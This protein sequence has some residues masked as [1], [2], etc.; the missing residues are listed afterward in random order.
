MFLPL[1]RISIG[2]RQRKTFDAIPLAELRE[3]ILA[4]GLI[5]PL[6]VIET[7]S[8]FDLVCGERRLRAITQIYESGL[9]FTYGNS[10]VPSGHVPVVILTKNLDQL[11]KLYLEVEE[12]E[13]RENFSWQD[14]DRALYTI[15]QLELAKNPSQT[16]VDTARKIA[17]H[18]GNE[19]AKTVES[20]RKKVR[21]AT[22]TAEHLD[23]PVIA[24]ARNSNEAFAIILAREQAQINA[25]RIRRKQSVISATPPTIQV[26]KGD[27][28][29]IMPDLESGRFTLIC[30]DPPYGAG[31]GAKGFRDRSVHHHNYED[32]PEAAMNAIKHLLV[33][34]WRLTKP[35]AN[36]FIFSHIDHFPFFKAQ[37][38]TMG[39]TPFP[40]PMIWQKSLSEGLAPWGRNGPRRTYD[41][42][43]YA[44]KGGRGLINS[45]LDI[46]SVKRVH[47]S[48]RIYG[49]QKPIDLMMQLI[50][51]STLM[52]EAVLDPY[53]GSGATLAA[54]KR[55][56]RTGVGIEID[57]SVADIATEF[58]FKGELEDQKTD[59]E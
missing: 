26:I 18:G 28:T 3:S 52:G 31:A 15:H 17:E 46:L 47:R 49:A 41:P 6:S 35:V 10:P 1:S 36:I 55:L 37:C 50:E 40:V 24:K 14:R 4:R 7:D 16:F 59:P 43:F 58:I 29:K 21:Q 19:G 48:E 25:E 9:T 32:T 45:P 34:G 42:I 13:I 2:E 33:E 56:G 39:W 8:D 38:S 51:C 27:C 54:A 44:Q 23:D 30:T 57:P 5:H 11:D 22:I 12:N 53:L 20:L